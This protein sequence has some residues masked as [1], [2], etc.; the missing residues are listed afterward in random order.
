MTYSEKLKDPRWQKKR[1]EIFERDNWTCQLCGDN[2]ASLVVHHQDYFPNTNP[3]DY[4]S[5]YLITICEDCHN[6]E[7]NM[8]PEIEQEVLINI[9]LAKVNALGLKVLAY[10]S[11]K[12]RGEL[13]DLLRKYI[14]EYKS[15]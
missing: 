7:T 12:H 10:I 15:L 1:L 8:R 2:K 6:I 4:P 3:W 9:R 11:L 5:E 14:E 13:T